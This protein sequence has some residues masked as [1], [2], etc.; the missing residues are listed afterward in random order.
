MARKRM[1]AAIAQARYEAA[2]ARGA[3]FLER[4]ALRRLYEQ[5]IAAELAKPVARA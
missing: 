5:A 2:V 1:P 3:G 4:V